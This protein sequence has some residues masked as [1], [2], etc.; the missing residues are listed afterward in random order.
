MQT[1]QPDILVVNEIDF[2]P[3]LASIELFRTK[4][5][6]QAKGLG[7]RGSTQPS[8]TS[9]PLRST[10]DIPS[11]MDLNQNQKTNDAD[12]CFGFGNYPGQYGMAIYSRH[13]IQ[14]DKCRTFQK[15]LWSSMPNAL[16]PKTESGKSYY[17]DDVWKKLRLS[18]KAIGMFWWTFK[19]T[20][21]TC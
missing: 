13:P 7:E 8:P 21:S 15:L 14:Q 3:D 9:L 6:N 4:Y 17:P 16:Q 2:E 18:S 19:A 20:R 12:D 5:L 11:G 1:L 10:R